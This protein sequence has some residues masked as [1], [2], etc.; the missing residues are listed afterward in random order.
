[1]S[2]KKRGSFRLSLSLSLFLVCDIGGVSTLNINNNAQHHH[3]HQKST[4][5]RLGLFICKTPCKKKGKKKEK[6][7]GLQI[8]CP[9]SSPIQLR[10]EANITRW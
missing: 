6:K 8:S 3:R 4:G 5:L 2:N 7:T 9:F 1:M 10:V